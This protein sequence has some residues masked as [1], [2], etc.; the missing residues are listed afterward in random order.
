MASK[1]GAKATAAS[2]KAAKAHAP[3]VKKLSRSMRKLL[4][5][6]DRKRKNREAWQAKAAA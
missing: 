2:V 5:K 6:N 1:T 3:V 4:A